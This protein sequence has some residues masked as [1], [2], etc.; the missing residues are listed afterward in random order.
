MYIRIKSASIL[1]TLGQMNQ[2]IIQGF[3][4][5]NGIIVFIDLIVD[6]LKQ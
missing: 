3:F 5:V 1:H 4:A 2:F 6:K